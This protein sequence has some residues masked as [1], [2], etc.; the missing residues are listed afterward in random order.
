MAGHPTRFVIDGPFVYDVLGVDSFQVP[1]DDPP[2]GSFG[3]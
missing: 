1:D 2:W 3:R